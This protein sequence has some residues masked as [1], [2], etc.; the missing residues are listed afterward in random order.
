[1]HRFECGSLNWQ[2][3]FKGQQKAK[4]AELLQPDKL[5]FMKFL[6]EVPTFYT[7]VHVVHPGW[8]P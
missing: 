8:L 4:R 5:G 3:P 1:M 2:V 6:C 7:Q